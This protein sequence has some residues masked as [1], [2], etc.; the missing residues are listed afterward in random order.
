MEFNY[1]QTDNI[2]LGKSVKYPKLAP[3]LEL[4]L[5]KVDL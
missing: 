1:K 2:K 5:T 3:E 4:K